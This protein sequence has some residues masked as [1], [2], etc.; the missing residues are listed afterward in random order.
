MASSEPSVPHGSPPS[1]SSGSPT[2]NAKQAHDIFIKQGPQALQNELLNP[3]RSQLSM[4][5]ELVRFSFIPS[6]FF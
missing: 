2:L 1:S 4:L 5:F 6:N 3:G